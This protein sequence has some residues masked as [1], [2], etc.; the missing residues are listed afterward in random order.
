MILT[1]KYALCDLGAFNFIKLRMLE[2]GGSH[3]KVVAEL[4][5]LIERLEGIHTEVQRMLTSPLPTT[6]LLF[7][8]HHHFPQFLNQCV[9]ALLSEQPTEPGSAALFY[10]ET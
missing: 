4:L 10:L 8:N 3:L 6:T 7:E 1:T 5:F 9:L 2:V